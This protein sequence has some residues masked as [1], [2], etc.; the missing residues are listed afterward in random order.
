MPHAEHAWPHCSLHE[1]F[2]QLTAVHLQAFPG[3]CSQ[4]LYC[5]TDFHVGL[6]S[7]RHMSQQLVC[8]WACCAAD[9]AL[10]ALHAVHLLLKMQ[11]DPVAP[12]VAQKP[13]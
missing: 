2:R 11:I 7:V 5:Y 10:A 3:C 9:A 6:V 1:C 8:P 13:L 12:A 4:T